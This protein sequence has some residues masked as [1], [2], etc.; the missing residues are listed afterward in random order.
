MYW[1]LTVNRAR[2]S[3]GRS[4][5]SDELAGRA[6]TSKSGRRIKIV[7]ILHFHRSDSFRKEHQLTNR[8]TSITIYYKYR[9]TGS[10]TSCQR[11]KDPIEFFPWVSEPSNFFCVNLRLDRTVKNGSKVVVDTIFN[12]HNTSYENHDVPSYSSRSTQNISMFNSPSSV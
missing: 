9:N 2:S 7:D 1:F 8:C 12:A 5:G 11:M 10:D 3:S 6:K 4:R